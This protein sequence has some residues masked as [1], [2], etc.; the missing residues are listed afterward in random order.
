M[1]N[2]TGTRLRFSVEAPEGAD[3][4]DLIAWGCLIGRIGVP[5]QSAEATAFC[6]FRMRCDLLLRRP[7]VILGQLPKQ[8]PVVN[9]IRETRSR[10][11]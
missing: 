11:C 2:D 6:I 10:L 3:Q 9:V 1:T 5:G 8:M 4:K 7:S